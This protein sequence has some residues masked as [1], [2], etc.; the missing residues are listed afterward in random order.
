MTTNK[1]DVH[2]INY[3]T[4]VDY[5]QILTA[6]VDSNGKLS[7]TVSKDGEGH[8][9]YRITTDGSAENPLSLLWNYALKIRV[10]SDDGNSTMFY[11]AEIP[12]SLMFNVAYI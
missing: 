5:S 6:N 7:F 3:N 9:L 4:K 1:I 11:S 2:L 10:F 12:V 8:S